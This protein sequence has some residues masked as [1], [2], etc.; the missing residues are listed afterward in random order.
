MYSIKNKKSSSIF[1]IYNEGMRLLKIYNGECEI[2]KVGNHRGKGILNE[3]EKIR[4]IIIIILC[5]FIFCS[6]QLFKMKY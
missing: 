6:D 4:V 2:K 3:F 1:L 5:K